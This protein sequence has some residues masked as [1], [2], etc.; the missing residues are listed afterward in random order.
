MTRNIGGSLLPSNCPRILQPVDTPAGV[1]Q[2]RVIEA[3]DTHGLFR[4]ADGALL[5]KHPN[6]YSCHVLAERI[7]DGKRGPEQA[8]FIVACG[9]SITDDLRAILRED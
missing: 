3:E 5:A 2:V 8:A 9:G 4:M 1:L 6:G 7:R